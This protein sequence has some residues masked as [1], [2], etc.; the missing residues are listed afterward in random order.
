MQGR[1]V[2]DFCEGEQIYRVISLTDGINIPYLYGGRLPE[3]EAECILL[4]RN[5]NALNLIIG[6]SITLGGQTVVIAG[7]AAAPEY[8]Y[9]VQNERTIMA[10][11]EYFAVVYVTHG[12]FSDSY[13]RQTHE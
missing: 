7:L 13:T 1:M 11:P 3:N 4:R 2:R 10:Q 12:F 8:I 5:A 6:D 9:M